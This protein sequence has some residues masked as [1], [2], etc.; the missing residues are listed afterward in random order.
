[1]IS[2]SLVSLLGILSSFLLFLFFF[3][4]LGFLILFVSLGLTLL[5]GYLG[6]RKSIKLITRSNTL[7]ILTSSLHAGIDG[8]LLGIFRISLRRIAPSQFSRI[9]HELTIMESVIEKEGWE[10]DPRGYYGESPIA[11]RFVS[12]TNQKCGRLLYQHLQSDSTYV[13]HSL[14]PGS[15]NWQLRDIHRTNHAWSMV[16]EKVGRPWVVCVHGFGLGRPFLDFR[17]FDAHFLHSVMGFNLLFPILSFHGP[18]ALNFRSGDGFFTGDALVT[19]HAI[20]Q[21]IYDIRSWIAW[22]KTQ[23]G[24]TP[25]LFGISLGAYHASVVAAL[26]ENIPNVVLGVPLINPADTVWSHAPV[27]WRKN[28]IRD[29]LGKENINKLWRLTSPLVL[30]EPTA[31]RKSVFAARHDLIIEGSQ[32]KL[33][34]D[35]WNNS[36]LKICDTGHITFRMEKGFTKFLQEGLGFD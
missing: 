30:P 36:R 29:G 7:E 12:S 27:S 34:L 10:N 4:G 3:P 5:S 2:L 28:A 24:I 16:H 6:L 1:M 21:S 13:P 11:P 32:L 8:L 31:T 20:T 22:L 19:L 23:T 25:S 33:L 14:F 35:H 9:R 15:E 18:R 17:M 26:E